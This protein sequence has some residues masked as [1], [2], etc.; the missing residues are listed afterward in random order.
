MAKE[1]WEKLKHGT[2]SQVTR[3]PPLYLFGTYIFSRVLAKYFP[4][5]NFMF[6]G[7]TNMLGENLENLKKYIKAGLDIGMPPPIPVWDNVPNF[8]V[9]SPQTCSLVIINDLLEFWS[10]Q[11]WEYIIRI[12][13]FFFLST[14]F[15]FTSPDYMTIKLIT[16]TRPEVYS[17]P[18]V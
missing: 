15:L 17:P 9:F 7:K 13:P 2:L 5:K 12:H 4:H 18:L 8:G 16:E 6:Q 11:P 1:S 14:F 3:T 10:H